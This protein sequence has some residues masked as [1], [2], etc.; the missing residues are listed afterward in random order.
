MID[1]SKI[2]HVTIDNNI[3]VCG[4]TQNMV[5]FQDLNNKKVNGTITTYD[6]KI[7]KR[8]VLACINS[9]FQK[10]DIKTYFIYKGEKIYFKY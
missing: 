4:Y 5:L 1:T 9:L 8:K 6:T 10:G 7:I 2:G 3:H